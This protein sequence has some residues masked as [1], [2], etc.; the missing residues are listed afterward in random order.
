MPTIIFNKKIVPADMPCINHAD[1]GLTLGHGLF[2]TILVKKNTYPA[3]DY[4][5]KRL[6]ASAPLLEINLPFSLEELEFML[7]ELITRNN[8][9]DKLAGARV[10]IT[11][12]EAER[13]IVP[14]Q[15]PNPNFLITT[16]EC[17]SP[18]D[19]PYSVLIVKTRKNEHTIAAQVKSL[20][21]IDNILAKQ[22]AMKQEYDEAILLN[23]ASNIADGS[24]SN[25][26]MVKNNQIITPPICDG[27]LPG[28]VRAI[29]LEEF[30]QDFSIIEKSISPTDLILADE[31]FLTNALI[32]IKP[33]NKLNLK[34]FYSFPF[35]NKISNIL[36]EKKN[37]I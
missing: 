29:L 6:L 28:V 20:S 18:N 7:S 2:E 37:Y 31:I 19:K 11:H 24:I 10:T 32:G 13:G 15:R 16:F 22:E 21:Y 30:H 36:R 34:C 27:A 4:H 25:I 17:A 3:L 9:Q 1:R 12:G 33:V 26:F 23:T 8:L 14:V 35:A 5:W